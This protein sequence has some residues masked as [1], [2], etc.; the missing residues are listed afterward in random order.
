MQHRSATR[1][2]ALGNAI[3]APAEGII[4]AFDNA[5]HELQCYRG[6]PVATIDGALAVAPD[7]AM[8]HVLRGYLHLLGTEPAGFAVA[9]ASLEQARRSP[10]NDRERAH[11]RALGHLVNSEWRAAARVLEDIA[12]EHPRDI[13]ALQVGHLVDF[14]T[15]ESRMLRDRIA[16]AMPHWSA[17]MPGYHALLGMHAFGLEETGLYARAEDSGRKAV[18]LEPAD[19]WAWHAVA[20]C[21]EM[22]GRAD[23]GIR[24]LRAD[25]AAWSDDSFFAVHNW[26]HLALFHLEREDTGAVLD[27]FDGPIHGG[28]SGMI[29]DLID[30]CALLWRLHLLGIPLGDRWQA[31][32]DA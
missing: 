13:L 18:E 6:D 23:D 7:F 15:G 22:Q 21:M 9:A 16:R 32:A 12:I 17:D 26:W 30:A 1:S 20:H 28:R 5:L 14:Y 8:G 11:G 3:T 2:D 29:L 4:E 19:A 24:W 27:L 25:T 10:A 31:V